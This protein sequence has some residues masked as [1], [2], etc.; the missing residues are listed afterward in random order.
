MRFLI[1]GLF[2]LCLSA[3]ASGAIDR[4]TV[5]FFPTDNGDM[6]WAAAAQ[7]AAACTDDPTGPGALYD[8]SIVLLRTGNTAQAEQCVEALNELAD[9]SY[10]E[11]AALISALIDLLQ[12]SGSETDRAVT[13]AVDAFT[14][15]ARAGDPVDWTMGTLVEMLYV[16]STQSLDQGTLAQTY[17]VAQLASP[18]L[19]PADQHAWLTTLGLRL[20]NVQ[21]V[22]RNFED[23]SGWE[24][25]FEVI[26]HNL[27]AWSKICDQRQECG[28]V[29]SLFYKYTVFAAKLRA[30][31]LTEGMEASRFPMVSIPRFLTT[32]DQQCRLDIGP[33][34]PNFYW[35]KRFTVI[36]S[37][38]VLVKLDVL[39]NGRVSL[40]EIVDATPM[41]SDEQDMFKAYK[42]VFRDWRATVLNG[43]AVPACLEGGET[44]YPVS[45]YLRPGPHN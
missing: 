12:A 28:D 42:N 23:V 24:Q 40:L 11:E 5:R 16:V 27:G 31:Q 3:H 21:L 44:I 36:G 1:F 20:L 43:D 15:S 25:A 7:Q 4:D 13:K 17:Q 30:K 29:Q 33:K 8:S 35:P 34:S 18:S 6:N 14:V 39:P 32:F 10:R 41:W 19:K 2:S 22:E 9:E 45:I 26:G 37:A 38:G